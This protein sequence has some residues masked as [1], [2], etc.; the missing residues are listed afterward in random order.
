VSHV[1]QAFLIR[2]AVWGAVLLVLTVIV[3]YATFAQLRAFPVLVT[4]KTVPPAQVVLICIKAL[5]LQIAQP[6][7]TL[8]LCY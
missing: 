8:K 5:V 1:F 6:D 2:N 7:T 4:H 3:T